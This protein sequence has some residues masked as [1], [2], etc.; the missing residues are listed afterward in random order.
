[1]SEKTQKLYKTD[2]E[3]RE[4]AERLFRESG[5]EFEGEF[6]AHVMSTYE[7]QQMKNGLGVGYQKQ[8]SQLEYHVKSV[9]DLFLSMLNTEHGDRIQLSES[10]EEKLNGLALELS[11]QQDE[12]KE[13]GRREHLMNEEQAKL[14]KITEDQLKE[15]ANIGQINGK[16][17]EILA[18]NRDR[19]ERLSKMVAD[20]QDAV[21]QKQDLEQRISEI[22]KISNDLTKQ[23]NDEKEVVEALRIAQEEQ[24]KQMQEKHKETLE[25][26]N[27]RAEIA[28]EK[29]LL[30]AQDQA[31]KE[32][33]E[34]MKQFQISEKDSSAEIR[35]LYSELD[36][37]RQ[38]LADAQ[39]PKAQKSTV[40]AKEETND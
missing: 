5:I 38:Q 4:L 40:K 8:I 11:N 32:R 6:F 23:L 31:S 1:M 25:R 15:I 20:G 30:F 9:V 3:A 2:T 22:S 13:Y 29:A 16:N 19:I 21:I 35:N 7:L 24:I 18:E 36:R 33:G 14:L 10:Y 39:K 28:K 17:E 26:A 12:I 37:L 34:L 27:D